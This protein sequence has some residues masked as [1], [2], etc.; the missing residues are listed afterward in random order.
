MKV[1]DI[2]GREKKTN[3]KFDAAFNVRPRAVTC[4]NLSDWA[5]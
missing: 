5:I 4:A 2:T 3:P 1:M